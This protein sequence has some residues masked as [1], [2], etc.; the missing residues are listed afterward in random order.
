MI[1]GIGVDTTTIE[2]I[3][4]TMTHESF[5]TRVFGENER[6][7]FEQ[8]KNRAETVAANF[9]AKEALGKALATGLSGFVWSEAEAL[10]GEKGEPYFRFSGALEYF[11]RENNIT[12]HLS[13]TH[14]G[15]FSTAFVVLEQP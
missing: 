13:P 7:M 4:R 5:M 2:R 8:R 11:I 12:A 14:E 1:Y 3:E 10:R 6:A 9:A 15:G